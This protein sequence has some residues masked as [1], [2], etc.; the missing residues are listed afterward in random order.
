MDVNYKNSFRTAY[1]K[2][3]RHNKNLS[4]TIA[5][6]IQLFIINPQDQSLHLHRL[7]GSKKGY[8]SFS[9]TG[10]IRIVFYIYKDTTYFVDIGTHNQVY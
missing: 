10:D 4:K 6:K 7:K 2:R 3:F 9:V 8:Y 5:E 1:R